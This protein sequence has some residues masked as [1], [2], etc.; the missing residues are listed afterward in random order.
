MEEVDDVVICMQSLLRRTKAGIEKGRRRD[1]KWKVQCETMD[2]GHHYGRAVVYIT[3]D[4]IIAE[5][6]RS[7]INRSVV[8]VA[9]DGVDSRQFNALIFQD[10]NA[11]PS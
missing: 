6:G 5:G 4:I 1:V 8:L 11:T 9:K 10:S 3:V 7:T 2:R